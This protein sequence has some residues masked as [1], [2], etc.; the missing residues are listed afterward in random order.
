[1]L[2]CGKYTKKLLKLCRAADADTKKAAV[3]LLKGESSGFSDILGMLLGGS[4]SGK[5]DLLGT[6]PDGAMDAFSKK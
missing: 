5:G 6:L 1:V 4:G 2:Q 3:G